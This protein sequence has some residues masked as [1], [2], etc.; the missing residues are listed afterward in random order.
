MT[1][2]DSLMLSAILTFSILIAVLK[3]QRR[4]G[5][6]LYYGIWIFFLKKMSTYYVLLSVIRN[7]KMPKFWILPLKKIFVYSDAVKGG[8]KIVWWG[9]LSSYNIFTVSEVWEIKGGIWKR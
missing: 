6:T 5:E 3:M 4:D 8:I 7:T 9:D 2:L 1:V